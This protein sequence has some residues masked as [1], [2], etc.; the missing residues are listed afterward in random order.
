M[1]KK[2][3]LPCILLLIS[4]IACKVSF[5]TGYDLI[6][7]QTTTKIKRDFALFEIKIQRALIT[8]D[9][10]KDQ[11]FNNYQDFYDNLDVDL[12]VLEDRSVTLPKK[13]GDVQNEIKNIS[14][15]ILGFKKLHQIG[16]EDLTD[17]KKDDHRDLFNAVNSTLDAL[18]KLQERLKT[19]GK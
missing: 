1:N 11:D 12:K 4:L 16:F 13:S 9:K 15:Q 8:S 19:T 17:L 3:L 2:T 18:L 5:I 10:A 6:I 7:D 14:K